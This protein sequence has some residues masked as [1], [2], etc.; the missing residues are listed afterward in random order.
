MG[1][2]NGV[3]C[4]CWQVDQLRDFLCHR[5]IRAD[6]S[7]T[8]GSAGVEGICRVGFA[9]K[10][11]SH[12]DVCVLWA[13][14]S[15]GGAGERIVCCCHPARRNLPCRLYV[16]SSLQTKIHRSPSTPL[17]MTSIFEQLLL[18]LNPTDKQIQE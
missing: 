5:S 12:A 17:R 3:Q 11:L 7:S 10:D 1:N 4:G 6:G 18:S 8:V 14:N 15:F 9:G 2:R 13:G 16:V